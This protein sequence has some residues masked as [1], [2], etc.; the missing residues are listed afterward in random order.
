MA[1]RALLIDHD[2]T[3]L[4]TF[5]LRARV[6]ALA[7]HEVFD[8]E[9]DAPAFLAASH[10]RN[11]EQM[12]GMFSDDPLLIERMAQTYRRHYYA[13]NHQGLQVYPGIAEMLAATRGLGIAIAVVTSKL[14]S[15]AR[16]E[17]RAAGLEQH[18]HTVVGAEHVTRP[19][20]DAEPL[21][22]ALA[23]LGC[24]ARDALMVGDTS[25]DIGAAHAAGVVGAAALWGSQDR[26]ALLAANPQ[27]ALETPGAVLAV[28][29]G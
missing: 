20:P 27:H 3:L 15:G 1:Y 22:L 21:R 28:L 2:D 23:Q 11:L 8:V 16:G 13:L 29:R 17:L 18:V 10:G 6:L 4:S 12:A 9:V 14:G 25:A 24:A 26:A 19:K 5:E 7:L